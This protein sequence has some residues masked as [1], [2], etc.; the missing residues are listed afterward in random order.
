MVELGLG[1]QS[2]FAGPQ[3][4]AWPDIAAWARLTCTPVQPWEVRV[5]RRLDAVWL[6]AW[7]DGQPQKPDGKKP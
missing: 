6:K 1:R 7:A 4:L 2:G 5:L 3:P